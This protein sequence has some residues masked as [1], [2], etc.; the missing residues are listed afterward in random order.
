VGIFDTV[1]H[2]GIL[3]IGTVD[4]TVPGRYMYGKKIILY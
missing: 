4:T 3:V 1:L 2:F